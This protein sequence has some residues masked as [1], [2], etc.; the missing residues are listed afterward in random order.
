MSA[1]LPAKV[2]RVTRPHFA[3]S[4]EEALSGEGG[5]H[6]DGRWHIKGRR[7]LYT[8]DSSSLCTLERLAHADEMFGAMRPDRILLHIMLPPVSVVTV[9]AAQLATRD[10]NWR[11]EGSLLCRNIGAAW[12]DAAKHCALLVPSAVNPRDANI[13]LNPAHADY[14]AILAANRDLFNEPLHP[15]PRFI[16]ILEAQLRA[17]RG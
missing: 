11:D 1:G 14:S 3:R 9:T 17:M 15:D 5:L 6:D 2:Y 13:I 12:L 4:P 7:V 16:P 8:S 10:P